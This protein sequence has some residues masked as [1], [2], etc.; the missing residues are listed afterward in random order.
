MIILLESPMENWGVL[1]KPA[2]DL[3]H[4]FTIDV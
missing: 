1:G 2:T 3:D 4:G